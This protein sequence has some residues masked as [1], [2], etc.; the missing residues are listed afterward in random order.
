MKRYLGKGVLDAVKNVEEIIS[1]AV[2]GIDF[3]TQKA[4]DE[5]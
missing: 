5:F 3:Q 2:S 4:F 1:N